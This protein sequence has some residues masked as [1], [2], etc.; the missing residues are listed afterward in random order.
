MNVVVVVHFEP[1]PGR[2]AELEQALIDSLPAVHEEPGCLL[3]ALHRDADGRIVLIENW[4]SEA[5][6]DV[7]GAGPA[8]AALDA[9]IEGLTAS[10]PHVARL[11]P[12]PA[13]DRQRGAL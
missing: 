11:S 3:Y 8:V 2:E 12:L 1:V 5:E 7:H 6:L 4:E 13:G 9:R 10:P